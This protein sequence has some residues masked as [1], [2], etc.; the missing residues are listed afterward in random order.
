MAESVT[1]AELRAAFGRTV[2][3]RFSHRLALNVPSRNNPKL[4]QIIDRINHDDELY[5]L[6][7]AANVNAVER[8]GMTDHG[9][10][11]VK[12]VMN[13][14]VK[15]LRMLV[16]HGVEP[17]VVTNY[18]MTNEDAEVVV[19]LA[20]L[21]HDLGMSVHRSNHEE[22]SLFVAQPKIR[23]LLDGIYDVG[24]ATIL[25]AE[26]MHAIIAHRSGGKPLTIEAGIVR[27]SDALDMAK[28]RS[29]ISLGIERTMSI[30]SISAA[31]ID[32]VHIESGEDK[33]VRLRIVMSNSAGVFQLDEL[34]REKL[35]GSGLE[36]YVEVEA[37]I[38]GEEEKRL[39]TSAYRL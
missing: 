2:E 9:P 35:S 13:I 29:R 34:F 31:A 32:S 27:V 26:I 17:S 28:G 4:A 14:A 25:R 1:A 33:P 23:E 15:L 6:W 30:H 36:P 3:E 39:V 12:I 5:A 21:M 19:M 11:H 16:E 10:V 20:A 7:L 37:L 18:G 22:M 38:E 8:L 24:T